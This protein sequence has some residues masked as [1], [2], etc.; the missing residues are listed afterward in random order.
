M[1]K[2]LTQDYCLAIEIS[3]TVQQLTFLSH[4]VYSKF[5]RNPFGGI[6]APGGSK[7]AFTITLA[8]GFYNVR[9]YRPAANVEVSRRCDQRISDDDERCR[10]HLTSYPLA[11]AQS[12]M[13]AIVANFRRYCVWA[14]VFSTGRTTKFLPTLPAF[15]RP[16]WGW[17]HGNFTEVFGNRKLRV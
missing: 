14:G 2:C 6:G 11:G 7:F 3:I 8:I 9:Y 4:P 15:W 13:R 1:I 12:L 10:L 5:H 17:S 16:Y